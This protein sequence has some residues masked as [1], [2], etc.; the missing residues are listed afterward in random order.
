MVLK[1]SKIFK[2]KYEESMLIII[3]AKLWLVQEDAHTGEPKYKLL[4]TPKIISNF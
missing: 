4:K 2:D 1:I 3:I